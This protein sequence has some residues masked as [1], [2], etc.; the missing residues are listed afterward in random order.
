[1]YCDVF[2]WI[3][4]HFRLLYRSVT[5][6]LLAYIQ[7]VPFILLI[8]RYKC[9]WVPANWFSAISL[10]SICCN[11]WSLMNNH[12]SNACNIDYLNGLCLMFPA[13]NKFRNMLYFIIYMHMTSVD[14]NLA[15]DIFILWFMFTSLILC[16]FLLRCSKE[17]D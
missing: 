10:T 13:L 9:C 7:Q 11:L 17:I 3:W 16:W 8:L 12:K 15:E 5:I 6:S 1:M 14:R 2:W 4:C